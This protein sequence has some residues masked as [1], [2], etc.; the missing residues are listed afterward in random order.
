MRKNIGKERKN[1][2]STNIAKQKIEKKEK[3]PLIRK[4]TSINLLVD[5]ELNKIMI[6]NMRPSIECA[7]KLLELIYCVI[8]CVSAS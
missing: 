2:R 7:C 6:S 3:N 4:N 1:Q 8:L 5:E